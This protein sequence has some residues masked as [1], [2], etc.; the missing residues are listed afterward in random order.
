M[1]VLALILVAI[2]CMCIQ[3]SNHSLSSIYLPIGLSNHTSLIQ[4][5][6][7]NTYILA[8]KYKNSTEYLFLVRNNTY[9]ATQSATSLLEHATNYWIDSPFLIPGYTIKGFTIKDKLL[10]YVVAVKDLTNELFIL[11][12]QKVTNLY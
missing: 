11:T 2:Q 5:D 8:K 4:T 6:N 10:N 3:N 9:K 7:Y 1:E 12:F